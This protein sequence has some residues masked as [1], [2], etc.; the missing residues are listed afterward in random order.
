MINWFICMQWVM[1]VSYSVKKQKNKYQ[2]YTIS[3]DGG[4]GER[5]SNTIGRFKLLNYIIF[6]YFNLSKYLTHTFYYSYFQ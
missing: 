6:I 2:F 1:S 5:N 3:M 4:G